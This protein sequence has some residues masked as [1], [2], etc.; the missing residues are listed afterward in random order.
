MNCQFNLYNGDCLEIMKQIPDDSVDFICCD[1]PYGTTN[2]SW[3]SVIPF[4]KLWEQYNRIAKDK[5]AIALFGSEPFSSYL[6]MSNIKNYKY[7][8]IWNKKS[9]AN[10]LIAKY[11]PLKI[12][13][14]IS[15]FCKT[16]SNYYPILTQ[17]GRDITREKP[18][19]QKSDLISGIKSG[20]F[21][22]SSKNKKGT[23]RYPKNIIEISNADRNNSLHPT[24]KPVELLEYLV[25]TYTKEGDVV[26]DNCMGSGTTG[27]ACR[28]LNRNF[29]GIEL[30]KKYFEI[31]KKRIENGWKVKKSD[32]IKEQEKQLTLMDLLKGN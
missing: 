1:L 30:D 6:R 16:S 29:I 14:T 15:I 22:K 10:I 26:L 23:E 8:W 19:E 7:D 18:V 27:V 17:T 11:Q 25:K 32:L 13:E 5:A 20:K 4:D 21:I 28:N 3:D 9:A 24:Q 2:C 12:C 31:C